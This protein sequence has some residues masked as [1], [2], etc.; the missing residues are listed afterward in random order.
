MLPSQGAEPEPGLAETRQP[1]ASFNFEATV[2]GFCTCRS[3][4]GSMEMR[5][6]YFGAWPAHPAAAPRAHFLGDNTGGDST[7]PAYHVGQLLVFRRLL[8]Q[9]L[10]IFFCKSRAVLIP[11][12]V[13][14]SFSLPESYGVL[15]DDHPALHSC[16]SS[17]TLHP[18][19]WTPPP[20][21][22]TQPTAHSLSSLLAWTPAPP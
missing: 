15:G 22:P 8:F 5:Q 7:P 11:E 14:G 16:R 13:R 17:A 19:A 12:E 10:N 20:A 3:G 21:Q 9:E 6:R 1:R 2:P 4:L 18:P